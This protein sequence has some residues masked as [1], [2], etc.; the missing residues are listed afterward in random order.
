MMACGLTPLPPTT[1]RIS[2]SKCL[3]RRF[4]KLEDMMAPERVAEVQRMFKP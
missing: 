2:I 3:G 4:A 1:S